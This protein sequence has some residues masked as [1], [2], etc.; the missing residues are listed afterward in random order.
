MIPSHFNSNA[1]TDWPTLGNGPF[2]DDRGHSDA[3]AR[4]GIAPNKKSVNFSR[5]PAGA[6]AHAGPSG[7]DQQQQHDVKSIQAYY[8]PDSALPSSSSTSPAY[9]D[10]PRFSLDSNPDQ[11]QALGAAGQKLRSIVSQELAWDSQRGEMVSRSKTPQKV[12]DQRHPGLQSRNASSV[13]KAS[14]NSQSSSSN[15]GDTISGPSTAES[16]KPFMSLKSI[17]KKTEVEQYSEHAN[18]EAGEGIG[19]RHT[20]SE[21]GSA[22]YDTQGNWHAS[23]ADTSCLREKEVKKLEEKGIDPAL[24]VEMK[25]AKGK[26][27]S[28]VGALTGNSFVD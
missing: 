19:S 25:Q 22:T 10:E 21:N 26:G 20:M 1:I 3:S 14:N 6:S 15:G 28:L 17:L 11:N 2:T 5:R 12:G 4:I 18:S 7:L 8:E 13:T 16:A 9:P 24:Y 27:K 23:D